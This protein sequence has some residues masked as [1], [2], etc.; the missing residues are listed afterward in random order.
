M[1]RLRVF[2]P[3]DREAIERVFQECTTQNGGVLVGNPSTVKGM[4]A[5]QLKAEDGTMSPVFSVLLIE[6]DADPDGW[7]S[8]WNRVYGY[9]P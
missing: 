8:D 2:I 4:I 5:I 3:G 7:W 1:A 9:K 6:E